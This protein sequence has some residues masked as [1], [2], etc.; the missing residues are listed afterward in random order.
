MLLLAVVLVVVLVVSVLVLV[1]VEA[2]LAFVS[3]VVL[4]DVEVVAE[5][6]VL[7]LLVEVFLHAVRSDLEAANQS[8]SYSAVAI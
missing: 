2:P 4:V 1:F 5:P 8:C 7:L 6:M 3:E